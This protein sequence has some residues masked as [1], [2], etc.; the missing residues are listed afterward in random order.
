MKPLAVD[1]GLEII[2]SV[3]VWT[4][5]KRRFQDDGTCIKAWCKVMSTQYEA[6]DCCARHVGIRSVCVVALRHLLKILFLTSF[7]TH[8]SIEMTFYL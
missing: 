5:Q 2:L 4:V 6:M 3:W 8:D 7:Y 1:S